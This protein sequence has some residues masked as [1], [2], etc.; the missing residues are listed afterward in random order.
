ME[1]HYTHG[2][3]QAV[4]ASHGKRTAA[5]SAGYLLPY[6]KPGMDVLDVGFGP[7]TI[8]L[9]L[10]EAVAP[11]RVTGIENAAAP[12]A[13][14][15]QAA[16]ARA[17]WRTQFVPGDV[18]DLAFEDDSFDVVHA[19]QVLQ[20]LSDPIGALGEMMRVSR[21]IVAARDADY[22]GMFWYPE[23][24]GLEH[25]RELYRKIA[26]SNGGEPDAA[27]HMRAWAQRAI[28]QYAGRAAARSATTEAPTGEAP[29]LTV[30][31]STWIYATPDSASHWGESQ[32]QR[33]S[34]PTFRGQARQFGAS[35]E[36]ID[37]IAAAWR[38]WGT[39]PEATFVLPHAEIIIRI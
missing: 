5:N 27:R 8:T 13:A 6:L 25:W 1:S 28:E 34:G 10:A 17:D 16:L 35:E 38:Q 29:V 11:G 7:G 39:D 33:V 4:L 30:T 19:H 15:R 9:D 22:A 14:A 20:H 24:P 26:R 18:M 23:L 31:S 32:A 37:A 2:H 36:D 21:G 12:V 3:S